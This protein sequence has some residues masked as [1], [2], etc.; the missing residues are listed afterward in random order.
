MSKQNFP[1]VS[2][3]EGYAFEGRTEFIFPNHLRSLEDGIIPLHSRP[4]YVGPRL[5]AR[6]I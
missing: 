6:R 4:L 2:H 3:F 5:L 1:R